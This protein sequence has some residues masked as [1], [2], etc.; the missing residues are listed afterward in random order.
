MIFLSLTRHKQIFSWTDDA[1]RWGCRSY[2][3]SG[4]PNETPLAVK[5]LEYWL[6]IP[7]LQLFLEFADLN[8]THSPHHQ[9]ENWFSAYKNKKWVLFS[10]CFCLISIIR[11]RKQPTK[12]CTIWRGKGDRKF[13]TNILPVLNY[14]Y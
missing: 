3:L 11:P 10:I 1:F 12:T 4:I 5:H 14:L 2:T 6:Y 9:R 8:Y 13:A 7:M